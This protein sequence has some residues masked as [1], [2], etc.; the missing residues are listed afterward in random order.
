MQSRVRSV[1]I[2]SEIKQCRLTS[3]SNC[4]CRTER[5]VLHDIVV[6]S[7]TKQ[8]RAVSHHDCAVMSETKQGRPVSHHDCAVMS[9]TKQGRAVSYHDYAVIS[10]DQTGPSHALINMRCL[11]TKYINVFV[12]KTCH[13]RAYG[14][15]VLH[16]Q[17]VISEIKQ[18]QACN[19]AGHDTM[20]VAGA[21]CVSRLVYMQKFCLHSWYL[22]GQMQWV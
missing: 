2:T 14:V 17:F 12:T 21:E 22:Y 10:E 20:C 16:D 1:H 3:W 13:F 11:R 18:G 4:D 6:I 9:E 19:G 15:Q 8:G 5:A 7:E